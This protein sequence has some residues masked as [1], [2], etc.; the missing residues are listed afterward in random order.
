YRGY[1]VP[2]GFWALEPHIE[3]IAR[4]MDFDA[5]EFRLKNAVKAG[6]LHPVS[7]AWNEGREAA[8]EYI[9]TCGLEDCVH[10]GAAAIR[11]HE[12]AGNAEWHTVPGQ[13]HLRRGIGVACVMQGTAIPRLD[14]GAASIK[15]NDD[16]SFNMLVGATDLGTGSDTVLA[17]IAAE[18]LGCEITD[19]IAYSSDTD[20]TP[21][22]KGAYASS[23]TYISG[24]AAQI[25]AEQVADQIRQV[26]A[27]MLNSQEGDFAPV[28][29]EDVVLQDRA[30]W[31]P[32]GRHVT[33][34]DIALNSL[35]HETQHQIMGIGSYVSPESPPPFGAQFATITLDIET[36]Q[37]T[38]DELIMA[39]DS[40]VIINPVTA[41]GQ[42]EGGMV[43]ALGYAHCEEMVFD[44]LGAM[45]NRQFDGYK[46]YRADEVPDLGV[47]FVET[48]EESGPFG[49][50]AVA[51]IPMDGVGPAICNAVYDAVGVWVLDA[52]IL[53]EKV[54]RGLHTPGSSEQA[55]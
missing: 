39:V 54:W 6:D 28:Q 51:E 18:V 25:A 45:L 37:F 44:D 15:I 34:R 52:P 13:P 10:Q 14:M 5:L 27:R 30:A 42:I 31:A 49:A 53:P 38:V 23:T 47:I 40:G 26:A 8:P 16:G 22:D 33:H 36:G 41:S 29:P 4:E 17:Q 7:K 50:K 46:I 2:Q 9:R 55:Q 19:I 11:W 20:F 32:D 1:G 43:Q 35:H 12:R 21:F 24:R 3:W 48:Y